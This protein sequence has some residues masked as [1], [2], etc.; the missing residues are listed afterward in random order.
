ME[1]T[2]HTFE[3]TAILSVE[4]TESCETRFLTTRRA[5]KACATRMAID[6]SL[7]AGAVT[8]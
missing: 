2:I 7:I 1:M 8:A 6:C 5:N 4:E 3:L